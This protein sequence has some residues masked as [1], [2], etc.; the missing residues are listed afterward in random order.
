MT[1]ALKRV[2][3]DK[4]FK[5]RELEITRMLDHENV[6][7]LKYYFKVH[8]H[9]NDYLCLLMEYIPQNFYYYTRENKQKNIVLP[10]RTLKSISLQLMKGLHY[11]HS[12]GICHRDIKPQNILIDV[13]KLIIKLCDFGSAKILVP[14]DKN[15]SYICSRHYRA[16]ELIVGISEYTNVIDVW[17]CGCVLAEA[18]T[19]ET[20]FAGNSSND[21][22]RKI[23]MYL[24]LS[25]N[26]VARLRRGERGQDYWGQPFTRAMK[27]V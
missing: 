27:A 21:Q 5:N 7:S 10:E 20:L 24:N 16:P 1:I 9:D 17:S 8:Q 23:L 15:V 13:E 26:E 22:M 3:Q 11:I 19:G 25:D 4:R 14:H 18:V 2:L 6:I 12:L